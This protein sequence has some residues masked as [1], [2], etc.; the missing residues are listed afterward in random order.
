MLDVAEL[1]FKIDP[2]EAKKGG[3]AIIKSL[4]SMEKKIMESIAVI[5]KLQDQIEMLRSLQPP[6]LPFTQVEQSALRAA[7]NV[8]ALSR[9]ASASSGEMQKLA[10]ST[11]LTTDALTTFL[12]KYRS[13]ESDTERVKLALRTF[14]GEAQNLIPKLDRLAQSSTGNLTRQFNDAARAAETLTSGKR[15]LS[16]AAEET[17]G[18]F[19]KLARANESLLV[20]A[21]GNISS[22]SR[23]TVSLGATGA[24]AGLVVG[25]VVGLAAA[26]YKVTSSVTGLALEG[27]EIGGHL[28]EMSQNIGIAADDLLRLK[29]SAETSGASLESAAT[30]VFHYQRAAGEAEAGN[31]KLK[32]IFDAL[33]LSA[34]EAGEAPLPAFIKQAKAILDIQDAGLR[35]A[36]SQ[37]LTG[38]GAKELGAL[39][40]TLTEEQEELNKLMR[41]FGIEITPK[42]AAGLDAVDDRV[43]LVSLAFESLKTK[44]AEDAAPN[45]V[46]AL[47]EIGKAAKE[48]TPAILE[49]SKIVLPVLREMAK[50]AGEIAFDLRSV[51]G[52]VTTA[53]ALAKHGQGTSFLSAGTFLKA[54]K[55]QNQRD[56]A[57]IFSGSLSDL[58][59]QLGSAA[60]LFP[61][62]TPAAKAAR[63]KATRERAE[64][65]KKLRAALGEHGRGTSGQAGAEALFQATLRRDRAIAEGEVKAFVDF[66]RQLLEVLK[67]DFD[68]GLV[69]TQQFFAERQTLETANI[70]AQIAALEQQRDFEAISGTRRSEAIKNVIQ[71]RAEDAKISTQLAEL[72]NQIADKE[73][74]RLG[75]VLRTSIEVGKQANSLKE[76]LAAE[77]ALAGLLNAPKIQ[78]T[79][80]E[81]VAQL[82]PRV[83]DLIINAPK[84]GDFDV[85]QS[86]L[87]AQEAIIQGRRI[88]G[89][90][91]ERQAEDELI[92]VRRAARE[93]IIKALEFQKFLNQANEEAV[94][95]IDAQ[96]ASYQNLGAELTHAEALQQRFA[97]QTQVD[98]SKLNDGVLDFLAS[99]KTLQESLQDFRTN[100]VRTL[101]DSLDRGLDKL[102]EKFGAAGDALKQFL[103]DLAHLATTKLLEK[104]FG[105]SSQAQPLAPQQQSTGGGI[106]GGLL[107][108]GG[109][110]G[111]RSSGSGLLGGLLGPGG[112]APFNP[113]GSSGGGGLFGNFFG[114]N[115]GGGGLLSRIPL[116]GRLFGGGGASSALKPALSEG[117][118]A[119]PGGKSLGDLG[120]GLGSGQ[121]SDTVAASTSKLGS[122]A[123]PIAA[124]SILAGNLIAGKNVTGFGKF[125]ANFG[126]VGGLLAR[127]FFKDHTLSDLRK[128]AQ[129]QYGIN[130]RED[131]V[132]QQVK[133][134]GDQ[135]FAGQG[136]ARRHETE[137]I[138]LDQVKEILANYAEATGQISSSLVVNR[139]LLDPT[140][141]ANQFI[142]R[143]FGGSA[144][145]G[146]PLLVGERR[147][148]VFVPQTNG[149]II[150]SVAQF[151]GQGHGLGAAFTQILNRM[152]MRV[153]AAMSLLTEQ[154]SRFEAMNA[155]SVL[156]LGVQ[157]APQ[158]LS[159]GIQTAFRE[160][161]GLRSSFGRELGLANG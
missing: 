141:P 63:E 50:L 104:L 150:P 96:I 130:V 115:Q 156:M 69:S 91:D 31:K 126:V 38:R 34:K 140:N 89:L 1:G 82:P 24:A 149:L 52:N 67:N 58:S 132:L 75:I 59:A 127:L 117:F 49:V 137:T 109:L 2:T 51:T 61:I 29:V 44:V 93:E 124:A 142:R 17:T 133:E 11:G 87:A 146:V 134:I 153:E 98:F 55:E 94:A 80:A 5:K 26:L 46:I 112:T 118:T 65:E 147:P 39:Y 160:D 21:D 111:G 25:A 33:G 73:R 155:E 88:R 53:E 119:L 108:G 92:G 122:L 77:G 102:T 57:R 78:Q 62:E 158:V 48:I 128:L 74:D 100:S 42:A 85:L 145:A 32:A 143:E 144:V 86:Q 6:S 110:F 60:D 113:G 40:H 27:A 90:I 23:F 101:F 121:F 36:A 129:S 37:A 131:K 136:G 68:R 72:T 20:G 10:R 16:S 105:V 3:E 81:Q 106:L 30:A 43:K 14:G 13:L 135:V 70:D 28:H 12:A 157:K 79:Q 71:R 56:A 35:A 120:A 64:Q 107:G 66:N 18:Q 8:T 54:A 7:S 148:E 19:F 22:F 114:S 151:A 123:G 125:L 45:L 95:R 47:D 9:A 15:K 4:D 152:T 41:D 139:R 103:K 154:L 83:K 76:Q 138:Q 99:Q 116:I 84:I 97:K 161:G 159:D